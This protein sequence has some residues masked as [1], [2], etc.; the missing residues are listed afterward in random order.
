MNREVQRLRDSAQTAQKLNGEYGVTLDR[1]VQ[2]AHG[3]V[4]GRNSLTAI[5][6]RAASES[7][8]V[9]RFGS[10]FAKASRLLRTLGRIEKLAGGTHQFGGRD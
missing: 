3:D 9:L 8:N 10:E 6:A 4:Q 1:E 5:V 7:S 2:R